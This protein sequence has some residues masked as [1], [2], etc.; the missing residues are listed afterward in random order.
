MHPVRRKVTKT[1]DD[2][3]SNSKK[4]EHPFAAITVTLSS[5]PNDVHQKIAMYVFEHTY[6]HHQRKLRE[7]TTRISMSEQ[8][9][10]E[11]TE[12]PEFI[13]WGRGIIEYFQQSD[14]I[15]YT[16]DMQRKVVFSLWQIITALSKL[17]SSRRLL[18]EL[19]Q[20]A[21]TPKL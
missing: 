11:I 2:R 13:S 7:H 6:T 3:P 10:L 14:T 19:A 17:L 1:Q 16:K 4:Y 20:H 9:M 15:L 21:Q 18:S 12:N 5:L 8:R